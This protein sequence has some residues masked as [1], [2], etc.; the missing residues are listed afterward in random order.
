MK[1]VLCTLD[2]IAH[3]EGSISGHV[4]LRSWILRLG[5]IDASIRGV[6]ELF[7]E[8]L[9]GHDVLDDVERLWEENWARKCEIRRGRSEARPLY[10]INPRSQMTG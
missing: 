4:F 3:T 8:A 2:R 10:V 9:V 1:L 7:P 6:F 5:S